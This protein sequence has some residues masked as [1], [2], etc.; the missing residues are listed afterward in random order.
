VAVFFEEPTFAA[1]PRSTSQTSPLFA[2][3]IFGLHLV[4]HQEVFVGPGGAV[5]E[6]LC[7]AVEVEDFEGDFLTLTGA[8]FRQL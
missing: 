5:R 3:G 6:G 1:I 4:E 7:V 8:Q 2:R